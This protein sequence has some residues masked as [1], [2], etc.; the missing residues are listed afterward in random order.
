M[1]IA[2]EYRISHYFCMNSP[3]DA[4]RRSVTLELASL[5]GSIVLSNLYQLYIHDFTDF[6]DRELGEDGKFT[7]D[8]L[9]PYWTDPQRFPFFIRSEGKLAGFA[10]V[11]KGSDF[12]GD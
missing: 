7:C 6:V 9:A 2:V 1:L 11:K 4:P 5:Q 3:P 12:S 8:P 10:L